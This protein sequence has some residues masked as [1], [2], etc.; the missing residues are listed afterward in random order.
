MDT[1][2]IVQFI[3]E[4]CVSEN[5]SAF[6]WRGENISHNQLFDLTAKI[7]DTMQT[8]DVKHG[9][10]VLPL[11]NDT[12]AMVASFPGTLWI[13]AIPV[14]L[15]PRL[16]RKSF[17]YILTDSDAAAVICELGAAHEIRL[18]VHETMMNPRISKISK[19]ASVNQW[20][21]ISILLC[22]LSTTILCQYFRR[23]ITGNRFEVSL[24]RYFRVRQVLG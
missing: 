17:Q 11:M 22:R 23:T 8:W 10:R 19:T 2:N 15:N 21:G 20:M 5:R 6:L 13:G 7:A 16:G 3:I 9:E 14:P 1:I 12:L 18:V 24:S 4:R